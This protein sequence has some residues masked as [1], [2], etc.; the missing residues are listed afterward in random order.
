MKCSPTLVSAAFPL[1]K[2]NVPR[3]VQEVLAGDQTLKTVPPLTGVE[4]I[5]ACSSVEKFS[6]NG[7]DRSSSSVIPFAE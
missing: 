5:G 6:A 1:Q 2:L 7:C 3:T 4:P